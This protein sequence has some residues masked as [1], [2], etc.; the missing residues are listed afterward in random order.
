MAALKATQCA[1][2]AASLVPSPTHS[3]LTGLF[4]VNK[5]ANMTSTSILDYLQ[6]VCKR[7][8]EHHL[9]KRVLELDGSKRARRGLVKIG[10]GGTLDPLA[11]GIVGEH[12]TKKCNS[13][14][15]S[16]DCTGSLVDQ[17]PTDHITRDSVIQVL[18]AFKGE[19]NQTPPLYSALS[20]DGKRLY[21]YAREG[22]PLPREIPTRKVQIYDLDLLS[23]PDGDTTPDPS[24][25]HF[26]FRAEQGLPGE[27]STE[28]AQPT[29]PVFDDGFKP[30]P[31]S[32]VDP[33]HIAIPS[34]PR[35]MF[36]HIR[37]HCSSG[38]Y[39]RTLI[40]DIASHLGT[41]GHMT[42]LLRVEQ[43]GFKLE[44]ESTLEVGDCKDIELVDRAIQAGNR[45][46]EIREQKEAIPAA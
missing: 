29:A 35:G 1:A 8:K 42:D 36:F 15:I 23:F 12:G 14:N 9:V 28:C 3:A 38:T 27:S 6:R 33:N 17:A 45:I 41:V 22:I 19:I 24:L 7:N 34:S 21:D 11:R 46:W 43:S 5:P 20:M 18:K 25:K 30:K 44:G 26:G 32:S 37:V 4:A 16:K 13:M 2:H 39:I 10:H 40:A 31:T